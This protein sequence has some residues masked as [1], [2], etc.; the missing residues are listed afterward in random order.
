M[1]INAAKTA[2]P[3]DNINKG[4]IGKLFLF[5][6]DPKL[7]DVLPYWDRFPLVFPIDTSRTSMLGINMHYLPI[8]LRLRLLKNFGMYIDKTKKNLLN[9]NYDLIEDRSELKYAIPCIKRYL[10]NHFVS[11]LVPIDIADW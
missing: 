1:L 3:A 10:S 7:K 4:F 11:R 6:Y 9:I 5:E 2:I 8:T